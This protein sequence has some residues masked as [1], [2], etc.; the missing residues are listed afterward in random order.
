[1]ADKMISEYPTL[2][3][4]Q[5]NDLLLI[6]SQSDTYNMAVST[7]KA[8]MG[9]AASSPPIIQNGVWYTWNAGQNK[10][11]ST[12]ISAIGPKGDKGDPG[13]VVATQEFYDLADAAAASAASAA[14]SAADA[15][16]ASAVVSTIRLLLAP[17]IEGTTQTPTIVDGVVTGIVFKDSNNNTVRTDVVNVGETQIVE[18]RTLN[19]GERAVITTNLETLATTIVYTGV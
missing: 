7:L 4:A 5:P 6:S 3:D 9:T 18:T 10:Y 14:A 1:M 19:T 2:T 8:A 12:G 13:D 11:V 15:E 17:D 16:Q